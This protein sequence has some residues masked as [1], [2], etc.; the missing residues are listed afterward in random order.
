M[1]TDNILWGSLILNI[2]LAVALFFKPFLN[3]LALHLFKG[4]QE[5]KK[6]ER[7]ILKKLRLLLYDY[8]QAFPLCVVY[9]LAYFRGKK[10]DNIGLYCGKVFEEW[11]K[12]YKDVS[13]RINEVK[14]DIPKKFKDKYD[15][16]MVSVFKLEIIAMGKEKFVIGMEKLTTDLFL[17][18]LESAQQ[19]CT[20]LISD[21]ENELSK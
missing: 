13:D 10:D 3:T 19:Q 17:K 20:V 2:I 14:P 6:E 18:A 9:A 16:L 4:R 1:T 21:I 5:K 8:G 11:R 7:E 15:A 12:K